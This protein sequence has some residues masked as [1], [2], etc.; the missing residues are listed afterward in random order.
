MKPKT[1]SLTSSWH[2]ATIGV[3]CS[4]YTPPSAPK[5]RR[6]AISSACGGGGRGS[7]PATWGRGRDRGGK[8]KRGMA[9]TAAKPRGP[10]AKCPPPSPQQAAKSEKRL[11]NGAKVALK[12]PGL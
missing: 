8:R 1:P 12:P 9:G 10:L 3:T 2:T 6:P 5:S 7:K 11:Q 4:F